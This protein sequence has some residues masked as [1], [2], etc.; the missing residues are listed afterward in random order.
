VKRAYIVAISGVD[1]FSIVNVCASEKTARKRFKE[2][3]ITMLL[4]EISSIMFSISECNE[5]RYDEFID[6]KDDLDFIFDGHT[7]NLERISNSTFEKPV[8]GYLDVPYCKIC[9]LED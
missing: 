4:D 9:K 6:G 2:L 5:G 8:A 3:K 1:T 7:R